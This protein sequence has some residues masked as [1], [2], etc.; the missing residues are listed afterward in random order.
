MAILGESAR[1]DV[2]GEEP[3]PRDGSGSP[4]MGPDESENL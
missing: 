2:R 4:V 1:G 3:S